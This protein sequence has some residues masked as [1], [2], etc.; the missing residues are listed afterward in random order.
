MNRLARFLLK[1]DGVAVKRS[2]NLSRIPLKIIALKTNIF[3]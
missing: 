3:Y 2:T 1:T